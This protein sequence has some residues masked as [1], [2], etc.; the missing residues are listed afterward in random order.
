MN[1]HVPS[2]YW[3]KAKCRVQ[4][5]TGLWPLHICV[6]LGLQPIHQCSEHQCLLPF[7]TLLLLP[8]IW[9]QQTLIPLL[10][11]KLRWKLLIKWSCYWRMTIIFFLL[12]PAR[13]VWVW[14]IQTLTH[15]ECKIAHVAALG[16]LPTYCHS[17]WDHDVRPCIQPA[18]PPWLFV[19]LPSTSRLSLRLT[20]YRMMLW[21]NSTE[22]TPCTEVAYSW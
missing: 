22:Q 20:S 5:L 16:W 4:F 11:V 19:K 8:S 3:T 14:D 18:Q 15:Q 10:I 17:K 1:A 21:Q 7:P 9:P 12:R 6:S 13:Y 2:L